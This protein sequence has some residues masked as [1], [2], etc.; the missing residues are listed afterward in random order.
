MSD[1][2][3]SEYDIAIMRWTDETY[4][5]LCAI[6]DSWTDADVKDFDEGLKLAS[7]F[8][9]AHPFI[10]AAYRYD[11]VK[12]KRK[13]GDLLTQLRSKTELGKKATRSANDPTR[14]VG[15]LPTA[16]VVD[17]NGKLKPKKTFEMPEVDGRR[18]EHLSEY[19]HKLSS[20]LQKDSKNLEN[21]YLQLASH[22][23]RAILLA[24]DPRAAQEDIKHEAKETV[25][26]ES[27]ILNFWER[28][29]AEWKA[30]TGENID[31]DAVAALEDEAARL[32]RQTPKSAGD[33]T[34]VEIDAMD[35]AEMQENCRRAR[36]EANKKYVRRSDVQ[37]SKERIEQMKIRIAE[38]LAWEVDIPARA[39]ELCKKYDIQV[40]GLVLTEPEAEDKPAM[41]DFV[42]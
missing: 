18:P 16:K 35:D 5:R 11:A 3:K 8:S 19:V 30:L 13:L 12:R 33:H 2:E 25:R 27:I 34:K 4:P 32:T 29:D 6:A 10:S 42:S 28:V 41:G 38:L 31:E 14:Y 22:K 37:M 7:A 40:D 1:I 24:N 39:K 23:E 9:N 20:S 17:E 26:I 15:V 36:I 21:W